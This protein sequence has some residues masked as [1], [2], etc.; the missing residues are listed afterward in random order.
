MLSNSSVGERGCP[1]SAL[2]LLIIDPP[3]GDDL[4][5]ILVDDKHEKNTFLLNSQSEARIG[6]DMW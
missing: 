5:R 4:R 6:S 1:Q 3:S 2:D